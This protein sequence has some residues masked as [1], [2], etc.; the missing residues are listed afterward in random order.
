[1]AHEIV[2]PVDGQ[3]VTIAEVNFEDGELRSDTDNEQ[4]TEYLERVNSEVVWG[5]GEP[6]HEDMGLSSHSD[7]RTEHTED[8][9]VTRLHTLISRDGYG[10]RRDSSR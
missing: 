6:I 10:L 1:M 2:E 9:A 5:E 7:E 3:P 4:I 8:T